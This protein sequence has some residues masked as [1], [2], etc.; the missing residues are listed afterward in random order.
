[1]ARA[2]GIHLVLAT[3]RP[4]GVISDAIR[5]NTNLRLVARMADA[6]ES[7]DVLDNPAAARLAVGIPGR[8]LMRVGAATPTVV[9]VAFTGTTVGERPPVTVEPLTLDRPSPGPTVAPSAGG[10]TEAEAVVASTRMAAGHDGVARRLWL[11]PLPPLLDRAAWAALVEPSELPA[12]EL[13]A[14]ARGFFRPSCRGR[15]S[16]LCRCAVCRSVKLPCIPWNRR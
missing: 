8:V 9:Q 16:C 14:V 1:M 13:Y 4:R 10:R 5:A 6:E 2:T 3:Q 11:E 12:S 15:Q 7:I